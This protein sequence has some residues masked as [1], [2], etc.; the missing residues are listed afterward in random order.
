VTKED[1]KTQV[2]Q[3]DIERWSYYPVVHGLF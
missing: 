3:R 1:G 2:G